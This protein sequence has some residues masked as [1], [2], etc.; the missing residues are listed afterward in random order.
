LEEISESL[1]AFPAEPVSSCAVT[2]EQ[3]AWL[4]GEG[5]MPSP[6]EAMAFF[7]KLSAGKDADLPAHAQA[8]A[9][10]RTSIMGRKPELRRRTAHAG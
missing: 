1:T 7:A 5:A 4:A 2:A 8:E 3:P 9:E 10:E 6:E